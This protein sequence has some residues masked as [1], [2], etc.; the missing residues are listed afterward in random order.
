MTRGYIGHT[1]L[2]IQLLRGGEWV[3]SG[4]QNFFLETTAYFFLLN[5]LQNIFSAL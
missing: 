2:N 1:L 4:Q 3:I 5:A